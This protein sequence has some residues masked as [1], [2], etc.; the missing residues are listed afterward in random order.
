MKVSINENKLSASAAIYDQLSAYKSIALSNND[1][2]RTFGLRDFNE[3]K[4]LDFTNTFDHRPLSYYEG[5]LNA[6]WYDYD[7]SHAQ[8]TQEQVQ[9]I[10][11]LYFPRWETGRVNFTL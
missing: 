3:N 7:R 2:F 11:D 4:I 9:T 6:W 5:S 1:A 8:S 10:T